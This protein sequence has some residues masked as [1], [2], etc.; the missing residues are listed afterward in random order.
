MNAISR[1]LKTLADFLFKETVDDKSGKVHFIKCHCP[2]E[3]LRFYAE[4]LSFRAPLE[5]S[6]CL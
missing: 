1:S 2:F 6:F 5:V 3:V 4:E